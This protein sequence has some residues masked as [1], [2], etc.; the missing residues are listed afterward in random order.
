MLRIISATAHMRS[1][2]TV[3]ASLSLGW[4]PVANKWTERGYQ[5]VCH[6]ED[7]QKNGMFK[8]SKP[9]LNVAQT[10]DV[11]RNMI[12]AAGNESVV[13]ERPAQSV[14]DMQTLLGVPSK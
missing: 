10:V 4:I 7:A 2:A 12:N 1:G 6:P 14:R 9:G 3:P 5:F 11:T 8:I 13:K